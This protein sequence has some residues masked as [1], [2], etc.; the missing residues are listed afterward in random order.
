MCVTFKRGDPANGRVYTGQGK[1]TYHGRKGER[2]RERERGATLFGAAS[3]FLEISRGK[4]STRQ[5]VHVSWFD[6][7]TVTLWF[8]GF[9]AKFLS[10]WFGAR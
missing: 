7:Q 6:G 5:G 3:V 4:L 1:E 10:D 8:R 9:R 2:E